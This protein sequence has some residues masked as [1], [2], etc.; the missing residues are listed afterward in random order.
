[1]KSYE[2]RIAQQS[3]A[4]MEKLKSASEADRHAFI[5]WLLQS[6]LH[7]RQYL[8]MTA[9]DEELRHIDSRFVAANRSTTAVGPYRFYGRQL[10]W[11]S[12]AVVFLIAGLFAFLPRDTS[13]ADW[14]EYETGL[15][16]LRSIPLQ[17][18]SV[19]Q[20]N[21]QSN[22]AILQTDEARLVKLNAGEA[23]FTVQPDSAG[24]FDVMTSR[25]R[26]R[27]VGTRFNVYQRPEDTVVTVVSGTV[28]ISAA[29]EEP[30]GGNVLVHL[31]SGQQAVL[32]GRRIQVTQADTV[33]A[34]AWLTKELVFSKDTLGHMADEFNRYNEVQFRV[35][36]AKVTQRLYAGRFQAMEPEVFAELLRKD[37]EL[38]VQESGGTITVR[39]RRYGA[40]PAAVR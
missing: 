12:L 36:G 21:T 24:P 2:K 22:V 3:S 14:Q 15:G 18:G 20:L 5:E 33:A 27:A 40:T 4:W 1:M 6:K 28:Q 32:R 38:E 31:T 19:V 16:E 10:G 26:L 39:E 37:Q 34:S 11:W 8:L 13:S 9:A 25:G 35:I 23:F 17:D 29:D 30:V 7:V